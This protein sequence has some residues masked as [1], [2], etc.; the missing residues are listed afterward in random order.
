MKVCSLCNKKE[1]DKKN[2]HIVPKF[3]RKRLFLEEGHKHLI[4]LH[5]SG[6]QEK[7]QDLPKEDNIFC[8]DCEKNLKL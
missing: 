5:K 3:F 7:I 4:K 8:S 6:Q 2:S 1:A